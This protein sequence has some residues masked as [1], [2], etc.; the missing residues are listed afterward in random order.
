[1]T[2]QNDPA[3][4]MFTNTART[5]TDTNG[6]YVPDCVLTNFSANGECGAIQNSRFGTLVPG[7]TIA[8]NVLRGWGNRTYNWQT[9]IG[10]Q[11]QLR[12]GFAATVTYSHNVYGNVL[13]QVNTAVSASDFTSYC[14][15]APVDARL[16]GGGGNRIC[17]LHDVNQ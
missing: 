7:T 13:A 4:L 11:Q 3:L 6:N 17:G 8:D 16:P 9:T 2:E 14:V 10:L 1:V 12:P 15:T 5:W